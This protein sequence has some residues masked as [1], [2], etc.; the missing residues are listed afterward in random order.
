[1]NRERNIASVPAAAT[2][3][4]RHASQAAGQPLA[5]VSP[6]ARLT[7]LRINGRATG[8]LGYADL[9]DTPDKRVY[10]T[11]KADIIFGGD[12]AELCWGVDDGGQPRV[13][14]HY[15]IPYE[16]DLLVFDIAG[17]A[18]AGIESP[19]DGSFAGEGV[20]NV[21]ARV[22][23][24]G[25]TDDSPHTTATVK[26]RPPGGPDPVG[27]TRDINEALPKPT[28]TPSPVPDDP[29]GR[30]MVIIEG[31]KVRFPGDRLT[32][33]WGGIKLDPVPSDGEGAIVVDVPRKVIE[34]VGGGRVPVSYSIYD[35]AGNWSKYAPYADPEVEIDPGTMVAPQ[36]LYA[37]NA[38]V[39]A[40]IDLD[41]VGK[42]HLTVR[43]PVRNLNVGDVV[44][45]WWE[46]TL[47]DGSR[48]AYPSDDLIFHDEDS[49]F[50]L[51]ARIENATVLEAAGGTVKIWY[52]VK[53]GETS[54]SRRYRVSELANVALP[55]PRVPVAVG[56]E[57]DPFASDRQIDVLVPYN[58]LTQ[59]Y[60]VMGAHVKVTVIGKAGTTSSYWTDEFDLSSGDLGHD[61]PFYCPTREL[62]SVENG[63][64]DFSYEITQPSV[65][66]AGKPGRILATPRTSETLT[67]KIRRAGALPDYP[68]PTVDGVVD[69]E[70][71]PDLPFTTVRIPTTAAGGPP[72]GSDVTLNWRGKVP[73]TTTGRVPAT[74]EL[75]FRINKPHIDGNRDSEV[76]V[77]YTAGGRPS[78]VETFFV[79]TKLAGLPPPAVDDA[80]GGVLQPI[81]AKD[82]LRVRVPAALSTS[83]MVTVHFDTYDS[84]PIRWSPDLI[85]TV[86]AGEVAR[87]LGTTVPVSYTVNGERT[88]PAL[89]LN[90]KPIDDGD[91]TI[92]PTPRFK[93]LRGDVLDTSGMVTLHV[94]PWPLMAV[95]QKV[96]CTVHGVD[97]DDKAISDT[98]WR[99]SPVLASE[100]SSGC[101]KEMNQVWYRRLKNGSRVT[102]EFAVTFDGSEI[103]DNAIIFPVKSYGIQ[104]I[105]YLEIDRSVMMLEVGK[106]ATRRPTGGKPPY[107]YETHHPNTVSVDANGT[108]KGLKAGGAGITVSDSLVPRS[109]VYYTVTVR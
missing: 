22:N 15:T 84:S 69:G 54:K 92:L 23:Y 93:E 76:S 101:N 63:T 73:Y 26:C 109:Y 16:T 75:T 36:L 47:P 3:G 79:G 1:M 74:G 39:D 20:H 14:T 87:R 18:I 72:V 38:A 21:Y 57:L 34:R 95:N 19:I 40:L 61:V 8:L 17:A 6:K 82:G 25:S 9:L 43:V 29:S 13:I 55:A 7:D 81:K 65:S 100:L 89:Q 88:S 71:D 83:D 104:T 48:K 45:A 99:M 67:L 70:L 31:Y 35:V 32:V 97:T 51:E 42:D 52:V 53:G 98:L 2:Q 90:V 50:Y 105:P 64:A 5:P 107:F 102:I 78:D 10:V 44:T 108:V 80:P 30:V 66:V 91:A 28:V 12:E 60:L 56:D 27:A 49:Q 106:T 86:P 41:I 96:W 37:S 85:V 24:G 103:K 77:S 4:M 33:E 58:G 68:A 59:P 46:A 11:C 62:R 94:D